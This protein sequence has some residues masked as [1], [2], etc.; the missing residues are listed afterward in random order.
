M[1]VGGAQPEQVGGGDVL[2]CC[3]LT[4]SAAAVLWRCAGGAQPEQVSGGSMLRCFISTSSA[5]AVLKRCAVV[6]GSC[7]LMCAFMELRQCTA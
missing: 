4:C 7:G 5:A 2:P 3:L 6:F 1:E